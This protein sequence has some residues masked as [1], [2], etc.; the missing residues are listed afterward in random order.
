[1]STL[2]L[3][4]LQDTLVGGKYQ[5]GDVIGSGGVG[6]VYR[7]KHLW[8]E[9]EVAVKVLDPGLPHFDQLRAAFL[10]EARAT[11]QLDHPNVVDVFDM[12]EDE[13]GTAYLVM[14]LLDGPTLRDVLLEH[15]RLSVRDTAAI[16]LPLV[17]ALEKAHQ[18]GIVHSDFKPENIILSVDAFEVMTPKLLDFGVA[19]LVRESQPQRSTSTREVIV[20]TPQYMSPEQ[21]HDERHLIGPQTDVWGVGVVWY[22]CLTGRCPFDGETPLEVLTAVCEASI[23]FS[24]IPDD[25]VPILRTALERSPTRRTPSLA[26][27]RAE[28]HAA[29][30]PESTPLVRARPG[31]D[32]P[33]SSERPSYVRRTL[34][35]VGPSGG[36]AATVQRDSEL[37]TLPRESHRR[38]FIG[39]LALAA[40]VALAAW[41]TLDG[42]RTDAPEARTPS[43]IAKEPPAASRPVK[44]IERSTS[45]PTSIERSSPEPTSIEPVEPVR[46][47]ISETA[48]AAATQTAPA[49]D[50]ADPEPAPSVKP[51]V[52]AVPDASPTAE[53]PS[54]Q[55]ASEKRSEGTTQAPTSAQLGRAYEKPPELV[56][57]W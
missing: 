48:R 41:W 49:S 27:L 20:G 54:P 56:T 19:Q 1:M 28:L 17:D 42:A 40:A 57:E 39:G 15:G 55:E 43:A 25:L 3:A 45:E 14:E 7:A 30:A 9:R 12:G 11:V 24:G 53:K 38:A 37:L 32:R 5:L 6:T 50:T 34:Q 10:R 23:D 33:T 47:V 31:S 22:E 46:S 44:P 13:L 8:T 29:S 16:L 2:Q 18:L 52:N 4:P 21:A 26:R 35:G 51:T 36:D